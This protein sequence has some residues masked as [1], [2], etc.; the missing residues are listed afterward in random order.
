[1]TGE[2]DEGRKLLERGVVVSNASLRFLPKRDSAGKEV[3]RIRDPGL[4]LLADAVKV[5]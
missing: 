5:P 3:E 1:M 2:T 4:L